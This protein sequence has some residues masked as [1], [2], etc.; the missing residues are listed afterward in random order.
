MF[1]SALP[2]KIY[3]KENDTVILSNS[4]RRSNKSS[5]KKAE[6]AVNEDTLG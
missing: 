5:K 4:K 6:T 2:L 1:T 3:L